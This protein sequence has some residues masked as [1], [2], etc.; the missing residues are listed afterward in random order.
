VERTRRARCRSGGRVW[1]K[2]GPHLARQDN[3]QATGANADGKIVWSWRLNEGVE[4]RRR[5][6][7]G[8]RGR[9]WQ[10]KST[11]RGERDISRHSP[12]RGEVRLLERSRLCV[13]SY[14]SFAYGPRVRTAPGFPAPSS[15]E[16]CKREA[17]LGQI[18]SRERGPVSSF[19]R[20]K[21]R[22]LLLLVIAS[23][24]KQSSAKHKELDC[25][26]PTRKSASAGLGSGAP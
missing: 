22:S 8:K 3:A 12:L 21:L 24:A 20:L 18:V 16:G 25:S 7:A 19:C 14:V 10:V 1:L 2:D 13:R 4:P 17:R 15:Q 6:I 23:E 11:H 9:R 26:P 5:V